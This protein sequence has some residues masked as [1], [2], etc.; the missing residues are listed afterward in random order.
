M[1]EAGTVLAW[2]TME[3]GNIWCQPPVRR[4][5]L[6]ISRG[7]FE[8]YAERFPKN[9]IARMYLGEPFP[10]VKHYP[11]VAGAPAWAI[12]QREGLERLTDIIEWWIDNRM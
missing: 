9:R 4:G 11:P 6:N 3:M 12:Y 7:F 2:L 8:R 10:S 1:I 5:F